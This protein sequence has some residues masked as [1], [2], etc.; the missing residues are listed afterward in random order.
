[1]KDYLK[2]GNEELVHIFY[3]ALSLG[4]MFTTTIHMYGNPGTEYPLTFII[5]TIFLF[6]L[7]SLRNI[8]MKFVAYNDG[9]EI[10]QRMIY[11]D[12]YGF[13]NYDRLSYY[14]NKEKVKLGVPNPI[15]NKSSGKLPFPALTIILYILTLGVI[16]FPSM[17]NY[18]IKKIPHKF[19]GTKSRYDKK[20]PHYMMPTE[21]SNYRYGKSLFAGYIFY[22][23]FAIIL[24]Y[25]YN[26]TQSEFYLLF[27][28]MIFWIAFGT[29][30]PLIG[31][32]GYELFR[33]AKIGWISSLVLLFLGLLAILI[34]KRVDYI[35]V[36]TIVSFI[37][38]FVYMFWKELI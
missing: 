1:M 4:F 11:F 9:F 26:I 14:I 5:I 13:R 12:R 6:L 15:R 35:I 28:F 24:K 16:I 36:T 31:T 2:I 20:I 38:L 33:K 22:L 30:I 19:I 23:I 32:E 8:F 34:F 21:I 3:F 10:K 18:K 25:L 29:L 17:W 37:I 7:F 27:I